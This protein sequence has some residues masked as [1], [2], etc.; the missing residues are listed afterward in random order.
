M[1]EMIVFTYLVG[2]Y[3]ITFGVADNGWGQGLM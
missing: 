3:L 1:C 2:C